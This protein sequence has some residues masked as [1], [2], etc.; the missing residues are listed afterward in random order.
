MK[1]FKHQQDI[2]DADP[3]K[4]GIFHGTGGGKTLTALSLA[5]GKTLVIC[6]KTLRDDKTWERNLEKL[7]KQIPLTVLSK[8]DFRRDWEK[9]PKFDTVIMDEAHTLTGV[10][11]AI[12]HRNKVA[13]PKTS[14]L[15]DA[16]MG[17]IKK[18]D[19][20]RLYLL[21]ATPIRNPM[22]VYGLGLLL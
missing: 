14:Q 1:L 8:E 9:L 10:T 6:P 7:G 5:R 13:E 17:Y 4:C 3:K 19:P 18:H 15:F 11:P 12:R 16:C 2:I 20:E 21:T 22:A